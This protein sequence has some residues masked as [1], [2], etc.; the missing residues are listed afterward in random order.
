MPIYT[1]ITLATAFILGTGA[2]AFPSEQTLASNNYDSPDWAQVYAAPSVAPCPALEGYPD[3]HA[4]SHASWGD[5]S[6]GQR[7]SVSK[8]SSYQR[9]P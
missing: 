9:R 1:K 6:P 3:C 7:R 5:S 4:D 2:A 8:H